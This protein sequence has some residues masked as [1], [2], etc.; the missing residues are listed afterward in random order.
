MVLNDIRIGERDIWWLVCDPLPDDAEIGSLL[1]FDKEMRF[2][3]KTLEEEARLEN[4][5]ESKARMA[6]FL[7]SKS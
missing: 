6:A 1:V 4:L 3:L 2:E 5:A 7:K